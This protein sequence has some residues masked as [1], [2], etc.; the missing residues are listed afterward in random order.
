[1]ITASDDG[2][3]GCVLAEDHGGAA[4]VIWREA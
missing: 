4:D 3:G 2:A 1:M